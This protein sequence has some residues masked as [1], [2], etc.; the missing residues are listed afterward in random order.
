MFTLQGVYHLT[1]LPFK[2]FH[3]IANRLLNTILTFIRPLLIKSTHKC[4]SFLSIKSFT[5]HCN[6]FSC[7]CC[8][9]KWPSLFNLFRTRYKLGHR[10]IHDFCWYK[11]G[12][13]KLFWSSI[14]PYIIGSLDKIYPKQPIRPNRSPIVLNRSPEGLR[15][16]LCQP[17]IKVNYCS[18]S[19]ISS[20]SRDV[21]LYFQHFF[22]FYSFRLTF[23]SLGL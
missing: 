20:S 22:Y 9:I 23:S 21:V 10:R 7:G 14:H 2:Y 1:C 4:K 13:A 15:P 5:I 11:S 17:L 8:K 19:S 3:K 6:L 18:F 12:V 16:P